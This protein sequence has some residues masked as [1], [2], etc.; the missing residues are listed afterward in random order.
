MTVV[1][2]MSVEGLE[3]ISIAQCL[4]EEKSK[5]DIVLVLNGDS[6]EKECIKIC[7]LIKKVSLR[8]NKIRA[9]FVEE[10]SRVSKGRIIVN[11]LLMMEQYTI[12]TGIGEGN[13]SES[14]I[15]KVKEIDMTR[16]QAGMLLPKENS[17][18]DSAEIALEIAEMAKLGDIVG[19][20][21][22]VALR[23]NQVIGMSEDIGRLEIKEDSKGAEE[24][25]DKLNKEIDILKKAVS[26]ETLERESAHGII[27]GLKKDLQVESLKGSNGVISHYTTVNSINEVGVRGK[28]LY[29][30]EVTQVQYFNS[31]INCLNYYLETALKQ[32]V[33]TLIY[34]NYSSALSYYPI[35]SM[36]GK[37]FMERGKIVSSV[38]LV[39]EPHPAI[40]DFAIKDGYDYIIIID[41]MKENKNLIVGNNVF[42]FRVANSFR[43]LQNSEEMFEEMEILANI[44]STNRYR[45]GTAIKIENF[46]KYEELSEMPRMKRYINSSAMKHIIKLARIKE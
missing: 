34:D 9:I 33:L 27:E 29:F 46:D 12:I 1:G 5:K 38:I 20:S 43:D 28:V 40:L 32:R 37:T 42:T 19:M 25:Q 3:T 24:V 30:K 26:R 35:E 2:N 15:N 41:R 18:G 21:K 4:N 10:C 16:E 23:Y 39:K 7:G 13:I 45:G 36:D 14:Y 11:T 31:L 22:Y 8:G 17:L 44:T 6:V